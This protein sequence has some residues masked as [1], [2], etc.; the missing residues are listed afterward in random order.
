[1]CDSFPLREEWEKKVGRRRKLSLFSRRKRKKKKGNKAAEAEKTEKGRKN[2]FSPFKKIFPVVVPEMHLG[3]FFYI[4][5]APFR[6]LASCEKVSLCEWSVT[7]DVRVSFLERW[8]LKP[9]E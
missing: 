5:A 8:L 3:V 4:I 1:M 2:D 7:S 6:G 9:T